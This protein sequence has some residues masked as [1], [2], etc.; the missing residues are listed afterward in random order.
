M[1]DVSEIADVFKDVEKNGTNSAVFKKPI[2]IGK[3]PGTKSSE[4]AS[5]KVGSSNQSDN[6][7]KHNT[8]L[9]NNSSKD[10][11][12]ENIQ[13]SENKSETENSTRPVLTQQPNS[14]PA[15][16]ANLNYVPPSSSRNCQL[17]YTLEVLKDGMIIQTENL[18]SS[19][20]PFLVFGRLPACDVVLQ[21][22]SI[23]R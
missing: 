18:E 13:L 2:V 17:P 16:N 5:D 1:D 14:I 22:P 10:E 9:E 4:R 21:H 3:R 20:K 8:S 6:L 7:L 23:S 15:K 11:T 19:P 12:R